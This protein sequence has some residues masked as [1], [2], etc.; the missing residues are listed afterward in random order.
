MEPWFDS[1]TAGII[2]GIIGICIGIAGGIIGGISWLCIR[3]GWKKL[4]YSMFGS[5]IIISF[6]LFIIGLIASLCKQPYHVWYPFLLSGLLGTII[7]S[8]LLPMIRRL[9]IE[10]EMRKMQAKDL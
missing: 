4:V 10:I 2:G 3:K 1:R 7:F 5:V 9:F 6:A 8:S